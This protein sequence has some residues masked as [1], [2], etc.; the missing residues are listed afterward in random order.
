MGYHRVSTLGPHL[1]QAVI[2]RDR[3]EGQADTKIWEADFVLAPIDQEDFCK[4]LELKRPQ[5]G[6]ARR[7]SRGHARFYKE[8][9]E[10]TQQLHDYRDAFESTRTRDLFRGTY[11]V[12]VF[13]PDLQLVIGRD[14]EASE[15]QAMMKFQKANFVTIRSWDGELRRL[16]QKFE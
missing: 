9:H 15:R 6:A 1:V 13:R 11:G 10:A 4:A 14:W 2:H 3:V 8:L 7:G 12:D 16:R 5:L